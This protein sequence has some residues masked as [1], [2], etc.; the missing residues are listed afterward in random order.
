MYMVFVVVLIPVVTILIM[1]FCPSLE[2][3]EMIWTS[4]NLEK[5]NYFTGTQLLP[6]NL[7]NPRK[8]RKSPYEL[9]K[10]RIYQKSQQKC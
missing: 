1:I 2:K 6:T 10:N 8:A 3:D 9:Q 5:D 7:F 4:P